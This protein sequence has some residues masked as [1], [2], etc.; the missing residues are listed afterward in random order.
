[1]LSE[2]QRSNKLEQLEQQQ[3]LMLEEGS[4]NGASKMGV[5]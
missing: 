2:C 3:P 5:Q 1:M 4:N